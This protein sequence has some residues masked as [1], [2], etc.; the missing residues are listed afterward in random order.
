MNPDARNPE[1]NG[2]PARATERGGLLATFYIDRE[3]EVADELQNL[4]RKE[5]SLA[6]DRPG[7]W[8]TTDRKEAFLKEAVLLRFDVAHDATVLQLVLNAHGAV[9][10][11][12]KTSRKK[13]E[14]ILEPESLNGVWGY[15]LTYQASLNPGTSADEAF[16]D[17]EEL[18]SRPSQK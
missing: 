6:Q 12:W 16:E 10:E 3:K 17:F 14:S 2:S 9:D 18:R 15:T 11:A 4:L 7:R 8:R 13:L 5:L 1:V